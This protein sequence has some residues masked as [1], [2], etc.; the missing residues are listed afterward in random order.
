MGYYKRCDFNISE[1]WKAILKTVNSHHSKFGF[2]PAP[3][4]YETIFK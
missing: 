1:I 3:S 4:D 2:M